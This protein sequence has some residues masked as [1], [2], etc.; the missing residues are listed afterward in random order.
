MAFLLGENCTLLRR[1]GESRRLDPNVN[2]RSAPSSPEQ[3][4]LLLEL[5]R[6]RIGRLGDF[7]ED[8]AK[9][10]LVVARDAS[11]ESCNVEVE[12]RNAECSC[13]GFERPFMSSSS[14]GHLHQKHP[15]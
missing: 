9:N 3:A 2:E 1:A 11:K 4:W 6:F 13:V 5:R 7:G 12:E 10:G 15:R 14:V 8:I